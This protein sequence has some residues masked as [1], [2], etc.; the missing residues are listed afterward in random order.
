MP[1]C[2]NHVS[3]IKRKVRVEYDIEGEEHEIVRPPNR[4][5][6]ADFSLFCT[7]RFNE[8]IDS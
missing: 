8:I 4:S 6:N 1:N 3:G 7:K 2:V 5:L